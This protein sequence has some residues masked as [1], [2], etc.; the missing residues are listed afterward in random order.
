MR[1]ARLEGLPEK[2]G[3]D[4]DVIVGRQTKPEDI[5]RLLEENQQRIGAPPCARQRVLHHAACTSPQGM[6]DYNQFR[7]CNRLCHRRLPHRD[8]RGHSREPPQA[9]RLLDSVRRHGL[10]DPD[11][12]G[13]PAAKVRSRL[14]PAAD[15]PVPGRSGRQQHGARRHVERRTGCRIG[16]SRATGNWQ[17][18][19]QASAAWRKGL[20]RDLMRRAPAHALRKAVG[21]IL[22]RTARFLRPPESTSSC[23]DPTVP[24]SHRPSMRS[25]PPWHRSFARTEVRGFAPTL[26]QILGAKPKSTSTPH[27]L[28]PRSLPT[29]LLRAGWWTAYGLFSHLSL[30]YA[31]GPFNAGPQRPPLRRHP[32]RSGALPLCGPKWVLKAVWHL[33][34]KPDVVI[35]L[36]GPAEILQARKKD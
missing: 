28:K 33:M 35:L 27:A 22:S 34:P 21:T 10:H 31:Q 36:H 4:I 25:K 6:P 29:S 7:L 11:G 1:S 24:A 18:V 26:K 8:G 15:G 13:G 9:W 3:S 14:G 32:R 2:R 17:P 16:R 19:E 23:S 12:Q 20:R 30:R 5:L